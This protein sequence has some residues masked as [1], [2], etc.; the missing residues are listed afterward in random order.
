MAAWKG[1]I[2]F[3]LVNIP[4]QLQNAIRSKD[5]EFHLL[6]KEDH[7]RIG[8]QKICKVCGK[9]VQQED[10]VKAYEHRKDEYIPLEKEELD[11]AKAPNSRNLEIAMFVDEGEIDTKLFEKPYY[12]LPGK[13]ADNLYVLLR[14]AIRSSGKIGVGRI[15]FGSREH[16]GALKVDGAAL[17]LLL[18]HYADE[19]EDAA[20]LQLPPAEKEVGKK[21]L[22]LAKQLV[23]S[24]EGKFDPKE[25]QDSRRD[26]LRE[27]IEGKVAEVTATAL[28]GAGKEKQRKVID[29]MERLRESLQ[30][31]EKPKRSTQRAAAPT[32]RSAEAAPRKRK[33]G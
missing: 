28:A 8:Y 15:G 23:A 2:S 16:L 13:N 29:L 33:V 4:V 27:T 20:N 21:E 30:E 10:L 6:H 12:V 24:L 9:V 7:G 1:T 31:S 3:G 11:E 14:E 19:L 5:L 17:V 22:D 25:F 32:R 26:K 18:M